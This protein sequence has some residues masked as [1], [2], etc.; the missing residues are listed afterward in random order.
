[1]P[2]SAEME[3]IK[4]SYEDLGMS[5]LEIAE[6][7][8]L[9]PESVK[10]TLMACSVKYRKD[11]G[12]IET[13]KSGVVDDGL[14]FTDEQLQRVNARIFELAVG[15]ENEVVALKAAMYIRDD[16]KGRHDAVKAL[17]GM[18]FNVLQLN[19]QFK[20]A[21]AIMKAALSGEPID[22]KAIA[23]STQ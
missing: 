17:G 19:Q 10:A 13:E 14:N 16:K 3:Q 11:C 21:D 8:Q 23:P 6:D 7:R 2:L 22:V 18:T 20:R 1:M 9:Q 12:A 4:I 15:S 5:P